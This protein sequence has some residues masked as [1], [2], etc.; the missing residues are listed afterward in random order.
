MSQQRK[1]N[2]SVVVNCVICGRRF[3]ASRTDA[4]YCDDNCRKKA[5]RSRAGQKQKVNP[6][7]ASQMSFA[8]LDTLLTD[9]EI[10]QR[11]DRLF[12]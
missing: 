9:R 2:Y 4:K 3:R 1:R 8:H 6:P 7:D 5:S 11:I 10:I 12:S